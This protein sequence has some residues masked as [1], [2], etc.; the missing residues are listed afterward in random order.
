MST[1]T[2]SPSLTS[3]TFAFQKWQVGPEPSGRQG[4]V[5]SAWAEAERAAKRAAASRAMSGRIE[6]EW[7]RGGPADPARCIGRVQRAFNRSTCDL[8]L[9]NRFVHVMSPCVSAV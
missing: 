9:V 1:P 5:V 7:G 6:G 2:V 8:W 3:V 4:P